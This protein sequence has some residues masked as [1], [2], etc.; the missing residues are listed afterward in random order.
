MPKSIKVA[1]GGPPRSGKTCFLVGLCENLPR[2]LRYLLRACPD[3][4]G[5]W[6]YKSEASAKYRRKGQFVP[7]LVDWYCQS[8]AKCVMAPIVLVDI[9]GRCSDENS[10]IL[11]EGGVQFGIILSPSLEAIPEW[12]RFFRSC[13]VEVIARVISDYNGTDDIT[14]DADPMVVHHLD[15]EVSAEELATRPTIQKV[16]EIILGLIAPEETEM[17][18]LSSLITPDGVITVAALAAALGKTAVERAL[19][20]GKV[21]PQIVWE[22]ADLVRIAELLHNRSAEMP[23]VVRIDGPAPAWL[24]AS[25]THECHPRMVALNS[26][27]GFVNVGCRRPSGGGEGINFKVETRPDDW[28]VVT[29]EL[30]PSVPLSPADLDRIAPPD[31]GTLDSKVILSG[32]GPNW[33]FASLAMAYHGRAAAVACFQPGTGS[34]VVWTH[35]QSVVLGDNIPE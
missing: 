33:L 10:R 15:R 3:G 26:A 32:R 35:T 22:G 12:E 34:T 16:A 11:R 25:L 23:E 21:I 20:N 7:G 19:P 31:L 18:I 14:I 4:E 6:T 8:L 9:G 30:D 5:T 28:K 24:V 2:F 27:D 13:G 1:I 29:F 17:N